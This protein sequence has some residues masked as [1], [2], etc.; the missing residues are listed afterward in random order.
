[1]QRL[2]S[3]KDDP[4]PIAIKGSV[5]KPHQYDLHN[6]HECPARPARG[7]A[8]G[9]ASRRGKRSRTRRVRTM[10]LF[11]QT[12]RKFTCGRRAAP[13]PVLNVRPAAIRSPS[14]KFARTN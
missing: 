12:S 6:V 14:R 9:V 8:G 4:I 3:E 10:A 11:L 7:P 13:C 1:V 2:Q 5:G